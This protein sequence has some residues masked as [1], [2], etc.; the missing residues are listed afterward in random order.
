MK[1]KLKTKFNVGDKV[2]V[3]N[4]LGNGSKYVGEICGI[5]LFVNQYGYTGL[6]YYKVYADGIG[7]KDVAEGALE[8]F[9]EFD[10]RQRASCRTYNDYLRW[11][12]KQTFVEGQK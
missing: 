4:A 3:S 12:E 6:E 11:L 7:V 2:V 1:I 8:S 10:N 5:R 9:E